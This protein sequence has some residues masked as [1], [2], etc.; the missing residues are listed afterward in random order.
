MGLA[1]HQAAC[2]GEAVD[3][4]THA[5]RPLLDTWPASPA[6]A[7]DRRFDVLAWN[8]AYVAVWGDPGL[9]DL[10]HRTLLW[11]LAGDPSV[12][13]RTD[14]WESLIEALAAQFRGRADRYPDDQRFDAIYEMLE[15]ATPEHASLWSSRGVCE[16]R[17]QPIVVDGIRLA[18]YMLRPIEDLDAVVLLQAPID[19][20]DRNAITK[21]VNAT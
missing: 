10:E 1:G 19:D 18:V 11:L 6:L 13:A 8:G 4:V 9:V 2:P 3:Q 20:V 21:L 12:R 16:F 15:V 7:L 5:L 17:T 14:G